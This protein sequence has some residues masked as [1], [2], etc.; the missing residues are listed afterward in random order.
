MLF[1][2][3]PFVNKLFWNS[4]KKKTRL[5]LDSRLKMNSF[6]LNFYLQLTCFTVHNYDIATQCTARWHEAHTHTHTTSKIFRWNG[7]HPFRCKEREK[8]IPIDSLHMCV[9]VV[10]GFFLSHLL[11]S[12]YMRNGSTD[13]LRV[14]WKFIQSC[15]KHYHSKFVIKKNQ[16]KKNLSTEISFFIKLFIEVVF[17]VV[18]TKSIFLIGICCDCDLFYIR[19]IF[20]CNWFCCCCYTISILMRIKCKD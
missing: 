7:A 11:H 6:L 13:S 9:C 14:F 15:A 19:L 8:P 16:F 20:G 4:L 1:F 18:R 2:L 3:I 10:R 5:N 17:V 12:S